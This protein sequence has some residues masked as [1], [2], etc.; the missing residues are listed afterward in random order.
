[1]AGQFN[2]LKLEQLSF[3]SLSFDVL[4][5]QILYPASCATWASIP[6]K[7]PAAC[8]LALSDNSDNRF[9]SRPCLSNKSLQ[10][11][12]SFSIRTFSLS[13]RLCERAGGRPGCLTNSS[14][15]RCF[16][17][18]N[19]LLQGE[20]DGTGGGSTRFHPILIVPRWPQSAAC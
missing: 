4:L 18:F 15:T 12:A 14:H 11:S 2:L 10:N 17:A 13:I 6:Q 3:C 19:L 9:W 5:A 8:S 20:L 1:M 7:L 16:R